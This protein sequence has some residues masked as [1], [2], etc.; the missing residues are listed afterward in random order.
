MENNKKGLDTISQD[1]NFDDANR[2]VVIS[3]PNAGGKSI[4][5]KTFGLNQL[6]LQAGLFIPVHPNSSMSIFHDIFTDIGDNQSIEN[7]LS[8]FILFV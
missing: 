6:M 5:L 8:T 2:V 1:I 4:A 7:E 3:G